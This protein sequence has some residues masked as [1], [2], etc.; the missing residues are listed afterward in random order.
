MSF[1]LPGEDVEI[2]YKNVRELDGYFETSRG[3]IEELWNTCQQYGNLLDSD[4]QIQAKRQFHDRFW[5]KYLAVTLL[6]KGLSPVKLGEGY[7]DFKTEKQDLTVHIEAVAPNQGAGPDAVPELIADG[8]THSFPINEIF[9]RFTSSLHTKYTKYRDTHSQRTLINANEPFVIALNGAQTYQGSPDFPS[10][11]PTILQTLFAIGPLA[12]SFNQPGR[13]PFYQ[14]RP[15]IR[16]YNNEDIY[17]GHF[18]ND[19]Y[20]L[21]SGV[22]YSNVNCVRY[23]AELGEDFLFIHNPFAANT[24]PSSYFSFCKQYVFKPIDDEH[25]WFDTIEPTSS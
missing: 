17:L 21:L 13:E 20:S 15:T 5:E 11:P 18:L 16:R 22:L 1:F 2:S 4:H 25:F 3:F 9:L 7:P 6:K 10:L 8:N 19:K 24:V 12:V 23:P 14:S